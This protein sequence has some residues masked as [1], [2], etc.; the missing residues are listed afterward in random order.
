MA[1]LFEEPSQFLRIRN[2]VYNM[3][4]LLDEKIIL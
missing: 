3:K 4:N 2:D 1:K